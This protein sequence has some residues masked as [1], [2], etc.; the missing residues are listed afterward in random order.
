MTDPEPYPG[1]SI[2]LPESGPRS[3]A[4][5]LARVAALIGDWAASMVVAIAMTFRH[6]QFHAADGVHKVCHQAV[7]DRQVPIR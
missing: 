4:S 7:V 1:A 3:L 6:R 5:I 2:G